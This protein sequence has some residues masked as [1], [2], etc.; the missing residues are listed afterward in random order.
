MRQVAF[1]KLQGTGNDFVFVDALGQSLLEVDWHAVA[2]YWCDRRRGIGADGLLLLYPSSCADYRMRILNADGSEAEMCGNGIRCF[3]HYGFTRL[4]PERHD[5]AIETGAGIRT[6]YRLNAEATLLKVAMGTPQPPSPNTEALA[7][8]LELTDVP[9]P[10]AQGRVSPS[11]ILPLTAVNTGTPHAVVFVQEGLDM[12]SLAE[13]GAWV[14]THPLF[15]Q[16]T[17]VQ[18]AQVMDRQRVHV[19]PWERGS[20]ATLACGTGACAVVVAGHLKGLLERAVQVQMPGGELGVEWDEQNQLWLM[21][22]AYSVFDGII[23][24]SESR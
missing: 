2:P 8:M 3:A 23:A 1:T 19:R 13:I 15:P 16:R 18:V 6:V 5:L 14:E 9:H 20:G 24:L 12:F 21:G 4:C 11:S 17:N 10:I 7:I 22:D